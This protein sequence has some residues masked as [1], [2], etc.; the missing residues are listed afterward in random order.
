MIRFRE[1]DAMVRDR[2]HVRGPEGRD[3]ARSAIGLV[4]P[5]FLVRRI[6]QEIHAGGHVSWDVE[7]VAE[8][9]RRSWSTL[10]APR[11]G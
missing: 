3:D 4:H 1:A 6:E 9:P 11:P 8:A 7:Q 5:E 10:R 2:P